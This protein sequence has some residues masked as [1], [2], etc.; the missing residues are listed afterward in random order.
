MALG[1]NLVALVNIKIASKWVFTSLTLI[2]IGFDTHPYP[3][4]LNT[5]NSQPCIIRGEQIAQLL[6][7][8]IHRTILEVTTLERH[9][10]I[11]LITHKNA[12]TLNNSATTL[13]LFTTLTV[14]NLLPVLDNFPITKMTNTWCCQAFR[15]FRILNL[16]RHQK[17]KSSC[18]QVSTKLMGPIMSPEMSDRM[19][20]GYG[21]AVCLNVACR[22]HHSTS[23]WRWIQRHPP[24]CTKSN[25]ASWTRKTKGQ[26]IYAWAPAKILFLSGVA[27]IG[28]LF[29]GG[30][31]SIAFQCSV[32]LLFYWGQYRFKLLGAHLWQRTPAKLKESSTILTA[33]HTYRSTIM[34]HHFNFLGA[35]H[36]ECHTTRFFSAWRVA[37]VLLAHPK[38][39]VSHVWWR[40]WLFQPTPFK[41]S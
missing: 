27:F 1:Q 32:S 34:K 8:W 38:P 25:I 41:Q 17:L 10:N 30:H 13:N 5:L 12:R 15:S 36:W 23:L 21:Y 33:T 6:W 16:F 19:P 22:H 7:L 35:N 11:Q 14:T 3:T 39:I 24:T 26:T 31:K 9:W 20:R 29:W 18:E 28:D 4:S 40:G 2:I 37:E